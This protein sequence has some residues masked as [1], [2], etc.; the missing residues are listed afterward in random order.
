MV[1]Y[2]TNL[3]E[4]VNRR[5]NIAHGLDDSV[6]K[7]TDYERLQRTVL[8]AMDSIALVIVDALDR[9]SYIRPGG[10]RSTEYL[11][12]SGEMR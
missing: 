2:E 3:D 5:N 4:L 9:T 11:W 12:I 6:V 1:E 10:S 8:Q 7:S